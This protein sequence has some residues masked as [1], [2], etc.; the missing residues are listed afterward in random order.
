[1]PDVPID[2]ALV[3]HLA[4]LARLP[5]DPAEI[6]GYRAHLRELL[7][8]VER[9]QAVDVRDVPAGGEAAGA[10]LTLRDDA[11]A[12]GLPRGALLE[13]APAHDGEHFLVPKVLDPDA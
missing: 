2:D 11:P 1:V 6:A 12:P 8:Y 3:R 9:L 5:L 13:G 7:A 4:A 10:G